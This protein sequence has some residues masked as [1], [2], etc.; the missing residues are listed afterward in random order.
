[1]RRMFK[2]GYFIL[3]ELS[4]YT[5]CKA[6]EKSQGTEQETHPLKQGIQE[7]SFI[8]QWVR[9]KLGYS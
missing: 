2:K 9:R 4:P 3:V 5:S 1:M 6:K 7:A 8:V